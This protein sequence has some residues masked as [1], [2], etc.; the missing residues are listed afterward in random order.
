MR[1]CSSARICCSEIVSDSNSATTLP[2]KKLSQVNHGDGIGARQQRQVTGTHT[3][4]NNTWAMA[5]FLEECVCAWDF[6]KRNVDI[7]YLP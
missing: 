5:C 6:L 2:S 7:M 4:I 3:Y 1:W